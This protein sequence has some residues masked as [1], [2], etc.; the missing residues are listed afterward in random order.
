MRMTHFTSAYSKRLCEN[1]KIRYITELGISIFGVNLSVITALIKLAGLLTK[2]IYCLKITE[3]DCGSTLA[4][5]ACPGLAAV[6]IVVLQQL[7]RVT[8]RPLAL[9]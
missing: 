3:R 5:V 9:C 7:Y 2:L 8:V 4:A 1:T 6:S